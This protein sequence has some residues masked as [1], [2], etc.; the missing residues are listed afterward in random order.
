MIQSI[1]ETYYTPNVYISKCG[2]NAQEKKKK[3]RVHG[4]CEKTEK[5]QS[6]LFG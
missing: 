4:Y 1:S 5:S 3:S 2:R 6:Q